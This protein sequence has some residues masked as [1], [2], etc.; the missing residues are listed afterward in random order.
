MLNERLG[1]IH[2]WL[3]FVVVQLDVRAALRGR[4]PRPAAPQRSRI[5]TN[6]QFLNDWASV[7]AFVLGFSMLVFLYNLVYS[8]LFARVPAAAEPVGV[9]L[10]RVAAPVAGA[11]CT[12]SIAFP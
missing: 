2:F 8:L 11:R 6:L 7:S 1:K 3:M 4:L 9:A 10:A 12:T 5:R